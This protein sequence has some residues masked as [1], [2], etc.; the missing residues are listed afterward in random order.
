M[1]KKT[2]EIN[3]CH[4]HG[5]ILPIID[6]QRR[7]L[8]SG[9]AAAMAAT[10]FSTASKSLPAGEGSE[11][12]PNGPELNPATTNPDPSIPP[13]AQIASDEE[14]VW[15]NKFL[16]RHISVDTH[17]HPGIFFSQG[18]ESEDPALQKMAS[19]AGFEQRTVADM[20]AGQLSLAL[21]ATVSDLRLLGLNETGLYARR[22]FEPGEA[23]A[24]HQRQIAILQGMVDS[25]LVTAVRSFSDIVTAKTSGRVGAMFSCEGGD[26]LEQQG[27]RLGEAWDQGVRS[28]QLVHY[29]VNQIGDI[30]TAEPKHGGLSAFGRE[31]VT[32]MN[33][34]GMIL[35]LAHATFETA[36]DAAELS[37]KP[38]MLSHSYI[39][40]GEAQHPRLISMD[41]ARL[42][43]QTGGLIGA[44][45]TGIGN[46]DFPAFIKH[47]LRLV[48]VV[49]IDHVGLG[50]DMDGNYMPVFTN[51]RQM[52]YL[53]LALRRHGMNEEDIGKVL[54]RNFL[55]VV[56]DVIPSARSKS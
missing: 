21:F 38:I 30:Q 18:L 26:F 51:Y 52:P 32:E 53:P 29:H 49:G 13:G 8:L 25:G 20:N 7:M 2:D 15:A 14:L 46:L 5:A 1:T 12:T 55:R 22:E 3:T 16:T 50:T 41:H 17:C 44:W 33:R 11:L 43:A 23:Y 31:A 42:I 45:P 9:V 47:L 37:T 35:D 6:R 28:I 27:E 34:L 56:S 36:R 39:A 54:G 10:L 19:A 40:E 4:Q 24:D 48:D